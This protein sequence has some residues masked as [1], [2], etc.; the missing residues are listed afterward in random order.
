MECT[1]AIF[2]STCIAALVPDIEVG[3]VVTP[4][5][6]II[7]VVFAGIFINVDSLPNGSAWIS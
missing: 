5:F 1:A 4:P 6:I 2:L 3:Q 7:F